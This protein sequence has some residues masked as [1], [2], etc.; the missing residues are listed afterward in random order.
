ML[1][2]ELGL[3]QPPDET[4]LLAVENSSSLAPYRRGIIGKRDRTL[5]P[6][7]PPGSIVHID[8]Q[9]RAISSRRDWTH[10]FKRPIY[11]LATRDAYVC[12]WCELDRNFDWLTIIPHPLSPASS[13]LWRY[14]KEIDSM[15]RVT[16]VAI[17]LAD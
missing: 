2:G 16:F 17:R 4:T 7:I 10:E 12:G 11:F 8:T 15:G 14:R 1:P 9:K 3:D 13:R 5:D 6:M